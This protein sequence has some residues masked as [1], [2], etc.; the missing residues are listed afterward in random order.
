MTRKQRR[1]RMKTRIS[2]VIIG[3]S[4]IVYYLTYMNGG[5]NSIY[6]NLM[7]VPI[8]IAGFSLG[9][10]SGLITAMFAGLLVRPLMLLEIT[11][12]SQQDLILWLIK[13]SAFMI[14]GVLA[15][16]LSDQYRYSQRLVKTYEAI[17]N[18]IN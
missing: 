16:Y 6:S 14:S 12:T 7:Y 15:G 17:A 9:L 10:K 3:L 13:L 4:A 1:K 8:L 5:I 2:V 18:K 11:P